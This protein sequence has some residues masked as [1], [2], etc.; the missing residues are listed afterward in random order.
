LLLAWPLVVFGGRG[1]ITAVAFAVACLLLAAVVRPSFG[2]DTRTL[3]AALAGVALVTILELVPLPRALVDLISPQAPWARDALALGVRAPS[4][5]SPLTI[6]PG[7]TAWAGLVTLGAL[8]LFVASREL[9]AHIGVRHAIRGI[10]AVG[11][12]VA[13][14][15]IAQAATAG[16]MIYWRFPTEYEGPLPFG[17]F[18]NRNHFATWAIMAVPL[19]V[20]YIAA[21]MG[22]HAVRHAHSERHPRAR[23][24]H[25]LDGRMMWLTV[26]GAVMLAALLLSASRSGI[27]GLSVAGSAFVLTTR[28]RRRGHGR[29]LLVVLAVMMVIAIARGDVPGLASRFG[30]AQ[31]DILGRGRIW[32]DTLPVL[33]DFWLTGSGAGTYRTVMLLYQ[34]SDRDVQ[35]NQAH[36]HYLQEAAEGGVLLLVPLVW[37]LVALARLSA[38]RMAA[39]PAG[40]FWIRAGAACGLL[41]VALQSAWETGLTMP[42]N[43]ALAAVL[44]AVAV[45]DRPGGDPAA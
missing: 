44:A 35:F 7:D 36:N 43:A 40:A 16:R 14:V 8:A 2:R 15:A 38:R 31:N 24:T 33:R 18:V 11:F 22:R 29:G 37:G 41:A 45:H 5:W 20:G 32:T 34:R 19:C 3:D 1:P 13:V 42:A 21:R 12:G 4:A 28:R 25:L 10:C 30:H 6:A 9:F 27:L 26:A 39:E 23:L 17:P